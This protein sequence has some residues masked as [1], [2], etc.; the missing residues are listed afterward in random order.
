M[1]N[2]KRCLYVLFLILVILVSVVANASADTWTTEV[3]DANKAYD[4]DSRAIAVDTGGNLHLTFGY[5]RLCYAHYD[6]VAG[7]TKLL[8]YQAIMPPL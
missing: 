6:G 4:L 2:A 1:G 7:V 3:V 5:N 8:I